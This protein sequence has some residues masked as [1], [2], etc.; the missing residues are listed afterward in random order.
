MCRYAF[1]APYKEHYVC[2]DC[3]KGFKQATTEDYLRAQGLGF[4]WQQLVLLVRSPSLLECRENELGYRLD[5][6]KRRSR[7]AV[8]PCPICRSPMSNLG[9]DLKI[10]PHRDTAAWKALQVV[11]RLG[12]PF[13]TCGCDGPGWIPRSTRD[14]RNYLEAKRQR[15][16]NERN[17]VRKRTDLTTESRLRAIRYWTSQIEAVEAVRHPLRRA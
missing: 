1:S 11:F 13:F 17:R 2:F 6:L 3:R 16:R 5:D 14:L 12:H 9:L 7:Q 15:F 8:R 4:V 10:P